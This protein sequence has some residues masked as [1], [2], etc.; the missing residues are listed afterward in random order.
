MGLVVL[1]GA[2]GPTATFLTQFYLKASDRYRPNIALTIALAGSLALFALSHRL[3]RF[4][5]S[6]HLTPSVM[7]SV[8]GTT[9]G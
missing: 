6:S 9:S 3:L 5:T 1:S 2:F 8:M 7:R 4:R